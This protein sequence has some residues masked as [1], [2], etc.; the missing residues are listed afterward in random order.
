MPDL[1]KSDK[2]FTLVLLLFSLKKISYSIDLS[3]IGLE[4]RFCEPKHNALI[5]QMRVFRGMR[6]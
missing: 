4:T 6:M 3:E 5:S 1:N 2:N